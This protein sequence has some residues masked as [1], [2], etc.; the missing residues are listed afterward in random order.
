MKEPLYNP[1]YHD[2]WAWSL[3]IKGATN[4]DIADAFGI[5]MRTIIRWTQT[6]ESFAQAVEAGKAIADS[7]V[8]KCLFTRATGFELKDTVKTYNV[9]EDGVQMLSKVQET[10]KQVPPDTMAIMYWLN[11]RQR[12]FWSQKQEVQ[13]STKDDSN[14]VLIYLP[15]IKEENEDGE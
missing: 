6:Y 8:E 5:T 12:G 13:L 3:A 1:L 11:N 14:D 7:K 15:A 4:K 2:D 10:A 9:D